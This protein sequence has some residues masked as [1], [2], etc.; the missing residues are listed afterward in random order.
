MSLA[1]IRGGEKIHPVEVE[2][3]LFK[4]EGIHT[5]SVIGVP[6]DRYGEQVC[7]WITNKRGHDIKL[8]DVQAFCKGKIAHYKVP[9]YLVVVEADEIPKTPSGKIQK[10]IMRERS[11]VLLNL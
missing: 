5:V 7:A 3:C 8:E 10:N 6:D 9:K 11:K 2:N 1:V 4:L